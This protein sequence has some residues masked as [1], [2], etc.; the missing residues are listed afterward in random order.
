MQVKI[1]KN[2][3]N[4]LVLFCSEQGRGA[5]FAPLHQINDATGLIPIGYIAILCTIRSLTLNV[6]KVPSF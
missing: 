2:K 1:R 4:E 3:R 5:A 6:H